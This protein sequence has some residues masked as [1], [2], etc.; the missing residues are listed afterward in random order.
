M[1]VA[2]TP[3][4][5]PT[6]TPAPAPDP[7][8][9]IA[10]GAGLTCTG[11]ERWSLAAP[12]GIRYPGSGHAI[13]HT[14]LYGQA[15][16]V[17]LGDAP[18][19][20]P[21]GGAAVMPHDLPHLVVS[22]WPMSDT[23]IIDAPSDPIPGGR[24]H[25]HASGRSDATLLMTMPLAVKG[26]EDLEEPRTE[27]MIKVVDRP[28]EDLLEL[29]M[30]AAKLAIVPG[31]GQRYIVCRL[32]EAIGAKLLQGLAN[33]EE[34]TYGLFGMFASAGVRAAL[35]AVEGDV[36][37]P[38]T[39]GELAQIAGIPRHAFRAEF[40]D[41]VGTDVTEYVTMRRIRRAQA[42]VVDGL[43]DLQQVASS[44]GFRTVGAFK[45]A[46]ARVTGVRPLAKMRSLLGS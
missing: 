21:A 34:D 29:T 22:K 11:V 40:Q 7:L 36:A 18:V 12:W 5:T 13:V 28:S 6:P 37:H 42:A 10:E 17:G 24:V 2:F 31:L 1:V 32:G 15:Y 20:I 8:S 19:K 30:L 43:A 41:V 46:A 45:K 38:W 35:K 44:V 39:V 14:V 25:N 23:H 33:E 4:P 26:R 9:D 27:P 3:M 16:V